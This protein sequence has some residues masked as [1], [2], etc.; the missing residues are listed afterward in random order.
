MT[1]VDK[2]VNELVGRRISTGL[3]TVLI[4]YTAVV[5]TA[6]RAP[7]PG[8]PAIQEWI[9]TPYPHLWI[10][11]GYGAVVKWVSYSTSTLGLWS[12]RPGWGRFNARSNY[13]RQIGQSLIV[14]LWVKIGALST[15]SCTVGKS[16]AVQT[17]GPDWR[18]GADLSL[19]CVDVHRSYPRLWIKFRTS[20]DKSCGLAQDVHL[21]GR[22]RLRP[23]LPRCR[24]GGYPPNECR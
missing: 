18:V 16:M 15:A 6:E 23:K 17:F 21:G 20:V 8:K 4:T 5:Q 10:T 9:P 1:A 13:P 12:S 7:K 14:E 2:P 19:R 24:D 11:C 3:S 22:R